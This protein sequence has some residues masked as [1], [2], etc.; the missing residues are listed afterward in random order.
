[1]VSFHIRWVRSGLLLLLALLIAI[2]FAVTI[3]NRIGF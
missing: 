1:M 2:T 3:T